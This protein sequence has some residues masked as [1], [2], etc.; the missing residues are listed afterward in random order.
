[1]QSIQMETHQN[2]WT[3]RAS[4][5]RG[6]IKRE[7]VHEVDTNFFN[8]FLMVINPLQKL[9]LL[10]WNCRGL[11]DMDRVKTVQSWLTKSNVPRDICCLQE[12]KA[13]KSKVAFNL[14]LLQAGARIVHDQEYE[15]KGGVA[16]IILKDLTVTRDGVKGDGQC[17][18]ATI[19]TG[20]LEFGI[21]SVYAPRTRK[22]MIPLWAW[23]ADLTESSLWLLFGDWNQVEVPEDSN[24]PTTVLHGTEERAWKQ[25][26][27]RANLVDSWLTC[28]KQIGPCRGSKSPL[29]SGLETGR[30]A[31]EN[32]FCKKK[33]EA[34]QF[35]QLAKDIAAMRESISR[36]PSL[37]AVE[38]L[39]AS[40]AKLKEHEKQEA[41]L[42]RRR[43]RA[44]WAAL[45]DAPTRY[46]FLLLKAKQRRE[47]LQF[48]ISD[49]AELI[50]D[51]GD[52]MR[53]V[54]E[55]YSTL[56]IAQCVTRTKKRHRRKTLRLLSR[57]ISLDDNH[58]LEAIPSETEI[59]DLVQSLPKGKSPGVDGVTVEMLILCWP[60]VG[61]TCKAIIWA[62]WGDCSLGNIESVSI[63]KL[64]PKNVQKKFLKNWRPISLTTL[65]YKLIAKILANRLKPLLN[66]VIDDEQTGFVTGRQITHN[67]MTLQLAKEVAEHTHQEALFLKLDFVKAF[68]RV[69][70][71]FLH[72]MMTA[73]GFGS[74]FLQ[75]VFGLMNTG[76]AKVYV[77]G[78]FTDNIYLTRGV[79]Q[80]CPIAPMLFAINTQPLMALLRE[81]KKNGMIQGISIPRGRA[82]LHQLF[83]DD[84]GSTSQLHKRSS[85]EL[86]GWSVDSRTFQVHS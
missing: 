61:T 81:E 56:Y 68:D 53:Y 4:L 23:L 54:H 24:C 85:T 29:E 18:W 14:G 41:I 59:E 46:F 17:A 2:L 58:V 83:A 84:S 45:G 67:I 79:R 39:Q 71:Q 65:A 78:L 34:K 44:R 72:D 12:L 25:L 31:D 60:F 69:E 19:K 5:P 80:G 22:E 70:H 52:I 11:G 8:L 75:L 74:K 50:Q 33:E 27:G 82:F 77:N 51:E 9:D 3:I 47:E 13:E 28:S 32:F 66:K 86:S 49:R 26:A 48:L 42:W 37:E 62:Y 64:L 10:S 43:T 55:Y 36:N 40:L 20:D 63:I 1:M 7:D 38:E 76:I 35:S 6:E 57:G 16:L 15:E 21:A 30:Q 73:L